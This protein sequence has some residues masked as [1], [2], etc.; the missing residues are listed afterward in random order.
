MDTAKSTKGRSTGKDYPISR[1]LLLTPK[2]N[3]M[4]AELSRRWKCSAAE[5]VRRLIREKALQ[6]GLAEGSGS[7]HAGAFGEQDG[8]RTPDAEPAVPAIEIVRDPA[9]RSGA[10]I[11]AGTRT[12]IHD[13]VG[14]ARSYKGDLEQVSEDALP[15]LSVDQIRAAMAWYEMHREEIDEILHRRQQG[16]ERLLARTLDAD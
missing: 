11:F 1:S 3:Q 6:V 13:V 12:A 2:D 8:Q 10:P 16:Y 5:V 14:Y 4:L 9:I 15:H 7:Q